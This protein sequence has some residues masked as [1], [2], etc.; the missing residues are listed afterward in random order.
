MKIV[1]LTGG[2][3]S[4]KTVVAE[5]LRLYGIPVY[6]SDSRSKELCQTDSTLIQQLKHLFG[7]DVYMPDGSLNRPFMAKAI[8]EDKTL[9]QA[10]NNLI[11]PVVG[12][13]FIEW[14]RQQKAPFVVQETAILF[15]A[16]LENRYD[17]IVCVTAP[18]ALRQERVLAR[19]GMSK[20]EFKARLHNQLSDNERIQRSDL[21]LVN[22][23][24]TPLIPQIEDLLKKIA[25]F[26][27]NI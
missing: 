1:G 21:I 17:I 14:V 9:M 10:A 22:D 11:H 18:E 24:V 13:D 8:F 4:G 23:E 5:L 19:S 7:D 25:N 26:V 12:L 6:D 2:I 3:G 16:G 15:E 20:E 27:P